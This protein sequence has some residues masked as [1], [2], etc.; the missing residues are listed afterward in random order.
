MADKGRTRGLAG[1]AVITVL[2]TL[3]SLSQRA[4]SGWNPVVCIDNADCGCTNDSNCTDPNQGGFC[5]NGSCVCNPGHVP[6]FCEPLGACCGVNVNAHFAAAG[7]GPACTDLTEAQCLQLNGS[8]QGDLTSCSTWDI[9]DESTP[10]ATATA[11]GTATSTPT[12]TPVPQGGDCMDVSQCAPGLFCSDE[13]C[14]D[15]ACAG[16]LESC[17]QPGMEGTCSPI[18]AQAPAASNTTLLLM[19]AVLLVVGGTTLAARRRG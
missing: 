2:G 8:Y 6:P 7:V 4:D 13:V 17:D 3:L 18:A 14:C 15:T 12:N 10:T 19:L 11:T 1:L 16:P 9:C 5:N